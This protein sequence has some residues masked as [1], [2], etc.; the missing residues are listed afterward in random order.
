MISLY[1][2]DPGE[3]YFYLNRKF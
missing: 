2:F 3:G 1:Y